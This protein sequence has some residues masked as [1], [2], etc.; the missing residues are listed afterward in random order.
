M[1][2]LPIGLRG[3]A[4]RVIALA[5]IIALSMNLVMA[6][7]LVTV[8]DGITLTSENGII[9]SGSSGIVGAG[10]DGLLAFGVNGVTAPVSSGV[11]ET[12]ADGVTYTGANGIVATGADG[13]TVTHASGIVATGA[14]GIFITGSDGKNYYADSIFI[15]QASG[16]VV[17][18]ADNLALIGSDGIVATGADARDIAHADGVRVTGVDGIT[19]SSAEGVVAIGA[20]GRVFSI[21]SNG[22]TISGASGIVATGADGISFAGASGIVA[23]GADALFG[24]DNIARADGIVAAGADQ[25]NLA[26]GE[27]LTAISLTGFTIKGS[28]GNTYRANS[29]FI[30]QPDGIVAT[31]ANGI[32]GT[33]AD[34]IVRTGADALSIARLS[35]ITATGVDGVSIF[36]SSGI[37]ATGADGG[38]FSISSNGVTIIGAEGIVVTG[39][40]GVTLT[41]L[42]G[43][44]FSGVDQTLQ[45]GLQSVDPELA[46]LLDKLTDDSN[47]NAA[48]VYHRAPS[49]ADFEDLRR[50]GVLGGVRYRALPVVALTANKAQILKI[51]RLP[52]VRAIYGNRTLKL[53]SEPGN[54]LT[55]T[56]RV[57][58][59]EDLTSHNG[60]WRI[61]GRGVTVAVLDSGIDGTHGDL[62]GRVVRNVKLVGMLGAGIGFN[63]PL[64]VE[65]LP[66]TDLVS[67]HGTFVASVIAGSG[68][69]SN[70]KY[71]GV[72]PGARLVGLSAG[73]SSLLFVLEGLDY[74]LWKGPELRVRVVNCSFSANTVYDPNDPINIATKM[75]AER[76]VNVVFSAGNAGPGMDSLNPYALAPWVISVGAMDERGRLTDF[77]ARGS[78]SR[79]SGPSLVAPGVNVV[80]ARAF[81]VSLT[82]LLSLGLGG[83]LS[84]LSP[85][86]TLSYTVGSGTSF[87]A[88]QVAGA[89]ALMLEANPLLTPGEVRDILRR[90][91]TPLPPYYNHEVGAGMLNAHAAVLEAAFPKRRMGMFRATLDR[92]Q[93]RFVNDPPQPFY[94]AVE[95]GGSHTINLTI[96]H[97]ALLASVQIAWGPLL[98]INDLA[99]RL[100]DPNGVMRPEV[101][102]L[103][104][105]GLTGRRERDVINMPME[106]T[107]R[108]QVRNALGLIGSS[109]PFTGALEVARAEYK[110]LLDIGG[111]SAAAQSEV[112]Q[113]LRSFVMQPYGNYFRPH[114]TVSRFDLA[115]ALVLGGRVPQYLPG[116]PRFIDARDPATMIMVESVQSAPGGPLFTDASPGG[117]FRPDDRATRLTAAIAMVRAAGLQSEAEAESGASLPLT[118]AS[119]IPSTLRGYVCV[120]LNRGLLTAEDGRFRPNDA[121]TRIELAHA[122]VMI[123]KLATK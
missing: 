32:V 55:G 18:G 38:I 73:D 60:G 114:F 49:D 81:G 6:G 78:F 111:L 110:P 63:Y 48:V 13:L 113:N 58:L 20:D 97:N 65:G 74:L 16:I 75:L 99:M 90:T 34:G 116:R 87:S 43:L 91:A 19:I 62:A 22:V 12:G 88:P 83:D 92:G 27:S 82:G 106:G 115:S 35:G 121:L 10:A 123:A 26:K 112:Y 41:G 120:A 117:R 4:R 24:I 25:L 33:G 5:L 28:G 93:T 95:A 45:T 70:G 108:L 37:V 39:A 122:M 3:N 118:D 17:T 80:G 52:A 9:Y 46:I 68:A 85:L 102:T 1:K 69:R 30:R 76:G 84:R 77:S 15:H 54:G 40:E 56:E 31:G 7:I 42:T 44:A 61:T 104:L 103:N 100:T 96:P 109:Q 23:T 66:N 86:E 119:A 50:I 21:S 64:S 107:W 101:N 14:D 29:V 36:S 67:G 59:D 72:A 11:V 57:K 8:G 79:L 71:V 51:S 94:G 98:T 2:M 105:P 89:I 53:M 47:V